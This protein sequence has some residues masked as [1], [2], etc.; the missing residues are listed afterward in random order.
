LKENVIVSVMVNDEQDPGLKLVTRHLFRASERTICGDTTTFRPKTPIYTKTDVMVR[1][2]R[3]ASL[4]A[5]APG[6]VV[7]VGRCWFNGFFEGD[8]K[9]GTFKVSWTDMDG[10]SGTKW[11]G[12]PAFDALTIDWK[13]LQIL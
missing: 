4:L 3:R 11:N 12:M 8:E 9:G 5:S 2:E 6:I 13:V 10:L 7:A 1:V